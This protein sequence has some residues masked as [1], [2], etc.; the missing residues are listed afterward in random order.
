LGN[1]LTF[2]FYCDHEVLNAKVLKQIIQ[3]LIE[4]SIHHGFE[5]FRT[6]RHIY[7]R[8]FREASQV[9]IDV[10]DNGK[11]FQSQ[12]FQ[13]YIR[14]GYALSNIQD[15]LYVAFGDEAQISIIPKDS[16]GAWVRVMIP[17]HENGLDKKV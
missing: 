1:H 11:G 3:P 4:N 2:T 10:I 6:S 12:D 16:P 7:I 8:C 14:N 13:A 5:N 17:Y 9:I 15:R